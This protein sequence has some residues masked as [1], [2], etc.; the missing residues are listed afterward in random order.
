MRSARRRREHARQM[1]R[2]VESW[3]APVYALPK[4]KGGVVMRMMLKIIIPTEAG[5]RT[6]RDG[7]LPKVLEATISKLNA[8]AAYFVAQDGLRNAM[9]FFDM[10]DSS[11]IPSIVEPLFIGLDAEVELLPVMNADDLRQGMKA[12]MEAM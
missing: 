6:I 1:R 4:A 5:N 11:D 8:E 7:S 10:R 9:I 12:A 3:L 2:A